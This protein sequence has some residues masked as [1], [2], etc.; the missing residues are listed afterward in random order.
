[1]INTTEMYLIDKWKFLAQC[2][3]EHKECRKMESCFSQ[4]KEDSRSYSFIINQ[5]IH[6]Q[7][8]LL[9]IKQKTKR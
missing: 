4:M 8:D 3:K 2:G 9:D 6:V 7:T 1:M 5:K